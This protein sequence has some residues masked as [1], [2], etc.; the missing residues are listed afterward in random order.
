MYYILSKP[1]DGDHRFVSLGE[2]IHPK[3]W[4]ETTPTESDVISPISKLSNVLFRNNA[5]QFNEEESEDILIEFKKSNPNRLFKKMKLKN[6]I[7][8]TTCKLIAGMG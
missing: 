5:L 8:Q 7:A 1:R 3:T 6:N 2:F 4:R